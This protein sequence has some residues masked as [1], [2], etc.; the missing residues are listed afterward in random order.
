MSQP[1]QGCA[2]GN[3]WYTGLDKPNLPQE[4]RLRT[5]R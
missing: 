4:R 3:T 5:G 2:M 1:V